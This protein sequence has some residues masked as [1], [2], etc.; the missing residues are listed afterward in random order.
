MFVLLTGRFV[1]HLIHALCWTLLHS[2]WQGLLLALLTGLLLFF[3]R[4]TGAALRYNCLTVLFFLFTGIT[5]YQFIYQ[6]TVA[7]PV[8]MNTAAVQHVAGAADPTA[9]LNGFTLATVQQPALTDLVTRFLN[10]YACTIVYIWFSL[11]ILKCLHMLMGLLRLKQIRHNAADTLPQQ[12]QRQVKQLAQRLALHMPVPLLESVH[13]KSPVTIGF[14]KPVILLPVSLVTC[15]SAGEV[16]AILLHE[17]AHIKR[18]DYLVNLLQRFTE[19][20]FFFNPAVLWLSSLIR[21]EREHCC[22]DMAIAH[23]AGR[24]NYLQALVACQEYR[25]SA[26]YA[27]A[28]PGDHKKQLLHRMR[29]I[30]SGSNTLPG[31]AEKIF[32]TVCLSLM[33][34]LGWV[35]AQSGGNKIGGSTHSPAADTLGGYLEKNYSPGE[36]A[37]GTT[38]KLVRSNAGVSRELYL[39]KTH[40]TLYQFSMEEHRLIALRVNGKTRNAAA[41]A[42]QQLVQQLLFKSDSRRQVD[43]SYTALEAT[44]LQERRMTTHQQP[45]AEHAEPAEPSAVERQRQKAE[46]DRMHAEKA[47][48]AVISPAA[49]VYAAPQPRVKTGVAIDQPAVQEVHPAAA[50]QIIAALENAGIIQSRQGLSY[51]LNKDQLIVNGVQQPAPVQEK[52]SK[53]FVTSPD[54]NYLYN[55]QVSTSADGKTTTTT[56]TSSATTTHTY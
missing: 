26:A 28:F 41:P 12:W 50:E 51:M 2:I 6:L 16:E 30:A 32:L 52:F 42:S 19:T 8:Y 37:E 5:G 40:D 34:L 56:S 7:A 20:I 48:Q 23:T 18:R 9:G 10:Q 3:T 36:I 21:Q 39:L 54:I 14:L 13:I 46:Q 4:N 38:L 49:P 44:A 47:R 43:S 17:L 33:L 27:L 11:F 25:S 55:I 1:D 53:K 29:R 22:D 31:S 24:K 35:Y 45:P 15:L